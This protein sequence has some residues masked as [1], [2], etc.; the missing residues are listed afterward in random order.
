MSDD[1]S[2]GVGR[3][4]MR[5]GIKSLHE[6]FKPWSREY[7]GKADYSSSKS[8]PTASGN[9]RGV[10][11][12]VDSPIGSL[13]GSSLGRGE[14]EINNHLLE[15]GGGKFEF[16]SPTTRA[17]MQEKWFR[18]EPHFH[19]LPPQEL[20]TSLRVQMANWYKDQKQNMPQSLVTEMQNFQN[21]KLKGEVQKTIPESLLVEMDSY[22]RTQQ[23]SGANLDHILPDGLLQEVSKWQRS[24]TMQGRPPHLPSGVLVEIE[25]IKQK[26]SGGF[27]QDNTRTRIK[28]PLPT[29]LIEEIVSWHRAEKQEMPT[30]LLQE[31]QQFQL[32]STRQ[33]K[34]KSVV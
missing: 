14:V 22:I 5:E 24:E 34:K 13:P 25:K 2:I 7:Y 17:V 20:P 18:P 12:L 30:S 19:A 26:T 27:L 15:S 6:E 3:D 23:R 28:Q 8:G 33:M 11:R 31:I 32:K 1:A 29:G 21:S 4:G 16:Q 10:D 9:G